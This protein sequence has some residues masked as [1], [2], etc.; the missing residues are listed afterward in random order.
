MK[1]LHIITGLRVGGAERFLQRLILAARPEEA[2]THVVISLVELGPIGQELRDAGVEVHAM[3]SAGATVA[4]GRLPH[5]VRLVREIDPDIVQTWMY[6]ADILGGIAAR[7]AARA[8]VVWNIRVAIGPLK[9]R[10]RMVILFAAMLSRFVPN[11]IICCGDVVARDHKKI[12]YRK[13]KI[14]VLPNGYDLAKWTL[15][16]AER[17]VRRM[18]D[19]SILS[20]GR[21][22]PQKGYNY[23]IE[24]A[25]LL[26]RRGCGFRFV[27][28]GKGCD[29]ANAELSRLLLMHEVADRFELL[30]VQRDI[31]GLYARANGFC[32]SSLFEGF[33][34]VLAEAMAMELPCV[35][36]DAGD[37][38]MVLGDC[39]E[40][41]RPGDAH[42]LAD[43]LEKSLSLTPAQREELGKSARTRIET[44]FTLDRAWA[45][46]RALY[47]SLLRPEG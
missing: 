33:P 29:P 45:R 5:L 37:A 27:L 3:N 46:Y 41:V 18:Q 47:E 25:A 13:S 6:H 24:A 14:E 4:L 42:M 20:V 9:A 23:L 16:E 28:A 19:I 32:L 17:A 10:T 11:R 40:I 22:D 30:G 12:G 31:R 44:N 43:A 21:F 2:V 15:T 1:I 26:K 36:T 7:L 8:P 38:K 35:S 34:N 39:G